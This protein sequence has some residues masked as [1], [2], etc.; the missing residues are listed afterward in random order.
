MPTKRYQALN[1][2]ETVRDETLTNYYGDE[3]ARVRVEL[4]TLHDTRT[5]DRYRDGA[6]RVTVTSKGIKRTRTFIGESAY[7][8]ARNWTDETVREV[9]A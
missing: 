3:L 7:H 6:R 4:A 2:W 5:G 8:L 9:A 1:D